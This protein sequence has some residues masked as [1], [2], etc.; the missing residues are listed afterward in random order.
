MNLKQMVGIE[1]A[2][3]VK[4]DMIVGLGTGSTAYYFIEELG[5]RVQ[6]EGL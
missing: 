4:D 5:R 2:S 1:A 6:E 3:Y